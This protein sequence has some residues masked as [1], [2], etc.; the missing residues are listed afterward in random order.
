MK[1][2]FRQLLNEC[3]FNVK[4]TIHYS[5]SYLIRVKVRT[6]YSFSVVESLNCEFML[7]LF[8]AMKEAC[9]PIPPVNDINSAGPSHRSKCIVSSTPANIY[10]STSKNISTPKQFDTK[11]QSHN[12]GEFACF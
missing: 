11:H 9:S 12:S 2:P 5:N 4:K 1:I 6:N 7:D 8:A 3:A 10:S